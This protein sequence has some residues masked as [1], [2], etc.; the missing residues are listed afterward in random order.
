MTVSYCRLPLQKKLHI[1]E[2]WQIHSFELQKVEPEAVPPWLQEHPSFTLHK[3]AVWHQDTTLEFRSSSNTECTTLCASGHSFPEHDEVC[4]FSQTWSDE[5]ERIPAVDIW[6]FISDLGDADVYLKMDVEGS[7][8][9]ILR[10]LLTRDPP[11]NLRIMWVETHARYMPEE[12]SLST[13][14]LLKEVQQKTGVIVR[15]WY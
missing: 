11:T 14:K 10:N 4:D 1:D 12:D 9:A 3:E 2:T 15:P 7:E 6:R 8:Y 13:K 5:T